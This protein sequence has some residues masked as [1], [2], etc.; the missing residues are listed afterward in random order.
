M[1]NLHDALVDAGFDV[2]HILEPG[3]DDDDEPLDSSR[4]SL[5]AK[6][7]RTRRFWAVVR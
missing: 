7:P 6:V 4:P 2:R 1:S 5:M 3:S